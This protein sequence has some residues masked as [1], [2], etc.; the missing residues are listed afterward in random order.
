MMDFVLEAWVSSLI[1][2]SKAGWML[3]NGKPWQPGEK[4][5]LLF[6]GY[7]G[8]RNM[9]S[10]ARVEEMLRQIRHILGPENVAFSVMSALGRIFRGDN[11]GPLAGYI[12]AISF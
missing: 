1:E 9:G 7:N 8:T 2:M 11:A 12:P 10:D 4:L 3:G 6:A 5:K